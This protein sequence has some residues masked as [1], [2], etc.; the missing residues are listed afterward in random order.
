MNSMTGFGKAEVTT[1]TIRCVAEVTSF[2]NRF[3][4]LSV[5]LPRQL[6]SLEGQLREMVGER[7]SRGKVI[8][9]IGYDEIG[10]DSSKYHIN[11]DA[12][13][14]YFGQI[15][16][17]QKKLKIPGK[18]Q[19]GDLLAFPEISGGTQDSIDEKKVWPIVEKVADKAL[20]QM[21]LMRGKEGAALANDMSKRIGIVEKLLAQVKA[22]SGS[23]VAKVREKLAK[24][25]QE[26][27]TSASIDQ[28]R[29][30]Q[31]LTIYADKSDISEECT[32]FESHLEQF[33]GALKM[34]EPVGKKLNFLLQEMNREA[35][36]IASK[37]SELSIAKASLEIKEEIEKLREQVQNVE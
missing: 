24:R 14:A 7:I 20:S 2:N 33:D 4:E 3:L 17:I 37:S 27:Q 8:V 11:S 30:E 34:K 36:T 26:F 5:K 22:E 25:I 15:A 21:A 19:I 18:V 1:K 29:L 23:V 28:N 35:N 12:V 32:R 31:E 9:Y 13:K 16:S 10:A 6:S